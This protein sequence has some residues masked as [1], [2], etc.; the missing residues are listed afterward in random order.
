MWTLWEL[1]RGEINF[2][3]EFCEESMEAVIVE[4]DMK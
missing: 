1:W 2:D 3:W 4:M